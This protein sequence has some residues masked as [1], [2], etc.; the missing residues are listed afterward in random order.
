MLSQHSTEQN[1]QSIQRWNEMIQPFSEGIIQLLEE[2]ELSEEQL[3]GLTESKV[4]I[5]TAATPKN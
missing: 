5:T 4:R 3:G 1:A 2:Q